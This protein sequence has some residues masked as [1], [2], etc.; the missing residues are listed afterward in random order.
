[1]AIC[2]ALQKPD[3]FLTMTANPQWP[4][5]VEALKRTDGPD[6][7]VEDQPDIVARVFQ[8]KKEALLDEIKKGGIFGKVRAMMHTIE[9]QKR[10]LPHMHLLIFLDPEDKIRTPAD[11]DSVSCAQI[12]DPVTQPI[13]YEIVTRCMVHGPCDHRCKKPDGRCSKNFQKTSM[14]TPNS[15]MMDI[16]IWHVLTMVVSMLKCMAKPVLSIPTVILSHT[17]LISVQNIT[18]T[19]MWRFVF[20]SRPSNI[21]INTSTRAMTGLH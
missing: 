8:L 16:P 15:P 14:S 17:I 3:I 6:Q 7:K 18:V 1:M 5:I 19:L 20:L 21:S 13:L 12:P 11:A 9:F 10:G 2:R 4:E